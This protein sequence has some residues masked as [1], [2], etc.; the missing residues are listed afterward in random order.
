MRM[1]CQTNHSDIKT[2]F[3]DVNERWK[4]LSVVQSG[5]HISGLDFTTNTEK[6][7][8]Y[9]SPHILLLVFSVTAAEH[10]HSGLM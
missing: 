6:S 1:C 2:V 7:A 4:L 3:D 5:D 8:K 10:F 9:L